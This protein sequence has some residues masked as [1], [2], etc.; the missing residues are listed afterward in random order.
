MHISN[1]R[2]VASVLPTSWI[3][4]GNLIEGEW[5]DGGERRVMDGGGGVM[6]RVVVYRNSHSLDETHSGNCY[7]KPIFCV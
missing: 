2:G 6:E 1:C 4:I 5:A 3:E 7:F